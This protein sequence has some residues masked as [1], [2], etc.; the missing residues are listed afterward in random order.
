MRLASDRASP[1][2]T[3]G[4]AAFWERHD[5]KTVF[6]CRR[7]APDFAEHALKLLLTAPPSPFF[8]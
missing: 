7:P 4:C 6:V 2:G 8:E 3:T 1:S 5:S